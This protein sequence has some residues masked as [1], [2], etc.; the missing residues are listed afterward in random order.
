M[1]DYYRMF[2][3]FA[4]DKN[5]NAGKYIVSFIGDNKSPKH[6]A[7]KEF[8]LKKNGYSQLEILG[9]CYMRLDD[10]EEF[11]FLNKFL[12]GQIFDNDL[13][14]NEKELDELFTDLCLSFKEEPNSRECLAILWDAVEQKY[15]N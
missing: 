5:D 13:R 1:S 11:D 10:E 4:I 14:L 12:K 6:L 2:F 15:V 9:E 3:A 7:N 8:S